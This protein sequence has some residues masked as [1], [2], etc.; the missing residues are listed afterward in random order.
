MRHFKAPTTLGIR[1]FTSPLLLPAIA[2]ARIFAYTDALNF[3]DTDVHSSLLSWTL[4][5]TD[6]DAST[7]AN[8]Y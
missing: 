6:G 3:T 7:Q 4:C 5:H 8:I 1:G 2:D